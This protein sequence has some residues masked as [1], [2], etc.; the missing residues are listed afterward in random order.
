MPMPHWWGQINKRIFNPRALEN[1]KWD[2]INHMG[3]TSGKE[4]RTPL[5]ATEI[6]GT[7]VFIVVY[8]SRSDWVQNILASG[9]ATLET[10]HEV[11]ELT[12]PRLIAGEVARPMLDGHV[13]LPPGF[14]KVD[15]YLQMDVVSRNVNV[16][17]AN[18]TGHLSG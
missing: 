6:D 17:E 5:A 7:F 3:R 15:Q 16:V 13:T 8:G 12:R 2:V 14:L 1:G 11:V 9:T 4:Y 10:G 18:P